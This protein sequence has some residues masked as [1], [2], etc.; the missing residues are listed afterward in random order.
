MIAK[1]QGLRNSDDFT[2]L[3]ECFSVEIEHLGDDDVRV[4]KDLK[5]TVP[6]QPVLHV[7]SFYRQVANAIHTDGRWKRMSLTDMRGDTFMVVDFDGTAY[8]MNDNG[9]TIDS[10]H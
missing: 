2:L 10:V 4:D 3:G 6:I 7:G 1:L 8:I 9:K 5:R